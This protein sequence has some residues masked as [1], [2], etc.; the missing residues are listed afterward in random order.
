VPAALLVEQA[1]QP[2][3]GLLLLDLLQ[4]ELLLLVLLCVPLPGRAFHQWQ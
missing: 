2:P 3:L 1:R 4:L